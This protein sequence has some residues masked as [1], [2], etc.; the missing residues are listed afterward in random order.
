MDGAR[1][2]L[3]DVLALLR[4]L[5]WAGRVPGARRRAAELAAEFDRVVVPLVPDAE[6]A[7]VLRSVAVKLGFLAAAYAD[8]AGRRLRPDLAVLAGAITRVY[9]DLIDGLGGPEVDRRLAQRFA[10]QGFAPANPVEEVFA[11][12]FDQIAA[13][14]GPD[15][16]VHADLARAHAYQVRSREQAE[17]G[18][19]PAVVRGITWGKGGYGVV[20]LFAVATGPISRPARVRELGA[21]LQLL[22]DYQDVDADRRAGVTTGATRGEVTLAGICARLAELR[23]P[24][25][26]RAVLYA[27]LWMA[28][29]RRR[30]PGIGDRLPPPRGPLGVLLRKAPGLTGGGPGGR[31]GARGGTGRPGRPGAARRRGGRR[32]GRP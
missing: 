2:L 14:L 10:G 7:R 20:V 4:R 15:D 12:L 18:V 9:D 19:D 11:A 3:R 26:M 17:P 22:D 6:V 31:A 8:L 5:P 16:P 23:L 13:R 32:G 25:R 21:V 24:R 29:V 27:A 1:G 28:L 30:L